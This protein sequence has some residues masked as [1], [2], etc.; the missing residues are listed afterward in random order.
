VIA[1]I[2]VG[3][4]HARGGSRR[5]PLKNLKPLGG[6]PLV[7]WIIEAALTARTLSRV[8]MSTDHDEIAR[9]ASEYGVEVPF[10]RPPDLSEDVPSE[11]VTQ[12][13]VQFLDES[14]YR[15]D[16]AVT[17]QPTTP[18]TSGVDIDAC[19]EKLI[20]TGADS[21]ITVGPTRERPEWMMRLGEGDRL[22]PLKGWWRSDEGVSQNLPALFLPNGGVYATRRDVLMN[23]DRIIGEDCR[24]VVMPMERSVDI[25][26]AVDFVL[27]EGILANKSEKRQ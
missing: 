20:A 8:I 25:D 6:K 3:I 4:I 1:P 21:V 23:Q 13:A 22:V 2:A 9:V 24:A 12:H 18:F 27:A 16:I 26:E 11:R 17:L 15:I 10:R 14:G 7:A 19:V 5:V